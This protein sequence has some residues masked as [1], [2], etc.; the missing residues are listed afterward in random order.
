[1]WGEND[2]LSKV[3][4]KTK[5]VSGYLDETVKSKSQIKIWFPWEII[6]SSK[7]KGF[8]IVVGVGDVDVGIDYGRRASLQDGIR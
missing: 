7:Y 2:Q 5:I 8:T 3:G 4:E 1:M 6:A